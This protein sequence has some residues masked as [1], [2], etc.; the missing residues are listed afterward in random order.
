MSGLVNKSPSN[1]TMSNAALVNWLRSPSF[2]LLK[3]CHDEAKRI[4]RENKEKLHEISQ[5]LLEKETITGE[6]FMEILDLP[7]EELEKEPESQAME[8]FE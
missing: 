1:P 8:N 6:E 7:D 2:I 4:L 5:V 3:E